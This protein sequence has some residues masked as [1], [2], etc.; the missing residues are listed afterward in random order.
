MKDAK[1]H[2]ALC[3]NDPDVVRVLSSRLEGD[4][5]VSFAHSVERLHSIALS[6]SLE[7]TLIASN[8]SGMGIEQTI[9]SYKSYD[10]LRKIPLVIVDSQG[11]D[12][13]LDDKAF[14]AGAVDVFQLPMAQNA[15]C[16]R[17]SNLLKGL[18]N[19]YYKQAFH[20]AMHIIGNA[21]HF[22]DE[23]TE[24]HVW[25]M[26]GISR[27]IGEQLGW[28]SKDLDEL[29]YAAAMH[30]TG[31]IGI[32]SDILTK[33]G[34]LNTAEW[35]IMKTHAKIGYELLS[36]S[37]HPI[38]NMAA[39]VALHHHEKWD[40]TGYPDGINGEKISL[41]ARIVAVADVFD[42][43]TSDRPYKKAWPV[44]V[45]FK[46]IEEDSG[47]HF[48]PTVV[49]AFLSA[50]SDVEVLISHWNVVDANRATERPR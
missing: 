49:S 5:K 31:K 12:F 43:L 22:F 27:L 19:S 6:S 14:A 28:D 46:A 48:D 21:G 38:L 18:S 16:K 29:Q 23:D 32:P 40:G 50:R 10:P 47:S 15:L 13:A 17:I 26:A 42:A 44:D 11:T 36:F 30:D 7:L 34:R 24:S 37:D 4:F 45:A 9:E 33:P 1:P 41:S 39:D 2:I 25:R 20:D 8:M 35:E 3:L